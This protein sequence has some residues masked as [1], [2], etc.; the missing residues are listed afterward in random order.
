MSSPAVPPATGARWL[1][2]STRLRVSYHDQ[3]PAGGP[4]GQRFEQSIRAVFSEAIDLLERGTIG[5]DPLM[6]AALEAGVRSSAFSDLAALDTPRHSNGDDDDPEDLPRWTVHHHVQ[7]PDPSLTLPHELHITA[8]DGTALDVR[9]PATHWGLAHTLLSTA[10]APAGIALDTSVLHPDMAALLGA[11]DDLGALTPT[12]LQPL[13][14]VADRPGI[15]FLGHN[16]AL[17]RGDRTAVLIDP[18]LPRPGPG[19]PDNFQPMCCHQLGQVDA[20]LITHGHPDHFD[21]AS[22]LRFAPNT[23]VVVPVVSTETVLAPDLAFRLRQLGFTDVR[24]RPWGHRESFGEVTVDVVPFYGEQA[25]DT[26]RLHPE[27]INAGN[28]YV[29][30]TPHQSAAFVADAGAD[31]RG[32]TADVGAR[33]RLEHGSVDVV[34]AGYR[35]WRTSP[36]DLLRSSVA[37]YFLFVP[38]ERWSDSMELMN[39]AAGA[40]GTAMAFGSP[41]LVPYADGGAPWFWELGLGPRLDETPMER[42]GYDPF[43]ERVID[44]AADI[45]G[46]P[47]VLL[48]RPGQ[49][50][51][52][53]GRVVEFPG[54]AWPWPGVE[55]GR[56]D[57]DNVR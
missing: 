11:L 14:G 1:H 17:V 24:P 56:Y 48:L 32:S 50:L 31:D 46:A 10:N 55:T 40:I 41:V 5:T 30:R 13:A 47:K 25:T 23:P 44:A 54:Y 52:P 16:A 18:F 53:S 21:P 9:L 4:I 39:D 37:R 33:Y 8:P 42:Q 22:L 43:P 29:V 49:Q 12:P 28:A 51:R 34:F 38:S 27:V 57:D 6:V 26:K 36:A 45:D 15:T 2:P 7:L 35:G 20:I 3:T 19:Y